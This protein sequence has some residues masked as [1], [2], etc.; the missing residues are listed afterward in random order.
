M[1][2]QQMAFFNVHLEHEETEYRLGNYH[3]S[4]NNI[5]IPNVAEKTF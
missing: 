3:F 5:L 2:F 1:S 4:K